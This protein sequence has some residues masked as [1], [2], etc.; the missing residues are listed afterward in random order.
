MF[1][2]CYH[3]KKKLCKSAS[4]A[5]NQTCAARLQKPHCAQLSAKILLLTCI[6][7]MMHWNGYFSHLAVL[8]CSLYLSNFI[9]C[10]SSSAARRESAWSSAAS[11]VNFFFLPPP[12]RLGIFPKTCAQAHADKHCPSPSVCKCWH[13]CWLWFSACAC[14]SSRHKGKKKGWGWGWALRLLLSGCDAAYLPALF[15]LSHLSLLTA[16]IYEVI[17]F[18]F[19]IFKITLTE[20]RFCSENP[21]AHYLVPVFFPVFCLRRCPPPPERPHCVV[22]VCIAAAQLWRL[23]ESLC[24]LCRQEAKQMWLFSWFFFVPRNELK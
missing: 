3:K 9:E 12:F 10:D 5:G 1:P 18:L 14:F 8:C 23:T 16:R 15:C 24:V 17:L 20:A 22:G 11:D 6:R 21:T 19:F 13:V 2:F 4:T 7:K